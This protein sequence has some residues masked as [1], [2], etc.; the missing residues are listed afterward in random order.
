[1][2][3]IEFTYLEV[4]ISARTITGEDITVNVER[5]ATGPVRT[6]GL[7]PLGDIIIEARRRATDALNPK[8]IIGEHLTSKPDTSTP[9]RT[10]RVG[11]TY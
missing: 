3:Q 9:E 6:T 4:R 10:A 2:S 5:D 8:H 7:D 11:A 1:M